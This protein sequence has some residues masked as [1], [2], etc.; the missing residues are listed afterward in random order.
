MASAAAPLMIAT[1]AISAYGKYR[2]GR[3]EQQM[4]DA[5]ASEAL[6]KGRSE[7]IGYKQMGADVLR[8]LNESMAAIIARSSAGGGD[9]ASG[10]AATVATF[11]QAD[12][13]REYHTATDNAVMAQGQAQVQADQYT[14]AGREAKRTGT[15]G[16][17]STLGTGA[18]AYGKL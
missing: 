10:S 18:I 13:A 11:S 4:Y 6:M 17:I 15:I 12:A 7:A 5:K 9:A 16:A 14:M 2:A 1:T 8:N 3:A